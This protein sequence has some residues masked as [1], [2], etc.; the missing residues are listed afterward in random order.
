[1]DIESQLHTASEICSHPADVETIDSYEDRIGHY[2]SKNYTFL[3]IPSSEKYYNT[4]QGW[5]KDL[6][7]EQV[8]KE[9]TH[10]MDV[11]RKMQKY[12]FLLVDYIDD[13]EYYVYEGEEAKTTVP[14]DWVERNNELIHLNIQGEFLDGEELLE[15][16][17][18]KDPISI[19]AL[20]EQYPDIA[21][22]ELSYKYDEQY[23]MIT[24]VDLN[25]RGMKQML[26]KVISELSASL[27]E[28]IESRYSDSNA[29][30]KHL[31]P[32]TIG[33]WKKDQINGL[34][35]H[36][37][38]HMNL[39]EMMQVIQS[40]NKDFVEECGFESKSD[41]ETLNSINEIRN[42]VMHANRSLVYERKEIS[43]I[44][45]MV[46]DSQRIASNISMAVQD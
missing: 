5:L 40:S 11:L 28:K 37:S 26:Y 14:V 4:E 12:P 32:V 23:G 35:M 29:I 21:D 34:D 42:R 6:E 43:E 25:K 18:E 39:L 19:H 33:R 1:M 24:L 13:D 45:E 41:V 3:P 20:R 2:E 31:R 7:Q 38:E 8:L 36:V 16:F 10:L 15:Y 46:N 17:S 44:I 27:G 22:S 9:D 30:L